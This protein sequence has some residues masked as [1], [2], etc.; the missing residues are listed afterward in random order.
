MPTR[1]RMAPQ[2]HIFF[3]RAVFYRAGGY[4]NRAVC[5][6][7]IDV[8]IS[9]MMCVYNFG[10]DFINKVFNCFDNIKQWYCIEP[11]VRKFI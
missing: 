11:I 6:Y 7:M 8:K 3:Y 4:H 10:F 9:S 1:L 5:D 2:K